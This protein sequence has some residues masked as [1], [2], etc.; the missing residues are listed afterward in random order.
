MTSQD[1]GND[2]RSLRPSTSRTPNR[3]YQPRLPTPEEKVD[4]LV[5]SAEAAK[6]RILPTPGRNLIT[7]SNTT[8][9]I[10]ESYIVVGS[11][12]DSTTI[13]KIEQGKYIDF[14]KLVPRDW[15]LMEDD[16]RLEMVM[17][18]GRT[19]YVP[20]NETTTISSFAK[21]EQAFRVY[22]NIYTK[23]HPHRSS[24]LIEYNHVIHTVYLTYIWDNVYLYDKDFCIH[25]AR[26]PERSW[27]IILQQAWALRLK[28]RIT[29]GSP[30]HGNGRNS[31]EFRDKC[32][33]P[34]KRYNRGR[35]NFGSACKYDHK[36]SYCFKFG[37]TILTCRKFAAD[38]D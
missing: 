1:H 12:L 2:A 3:P 14:G 34:C 7:Y 16:Q 9:F 17:R 6:G 31:D 30:S 20:V 28:D 37:H 15:V 18:G 38:K 5:R 27:G 32:N 25:I 21:W 29:S 33:E 8:A 23:A 10:D 22:S 13:E 24:E 26:N 36:C 11:H 19:Y 4:Q 35:C